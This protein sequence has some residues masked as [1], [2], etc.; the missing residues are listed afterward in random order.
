MWWFV[1]RIL[2]VMKLRQE[3][4]KLEAIWATWKKKKT[5][6]KNNK[7]Q[8]YSSRTWGF[9]FNHLLHTRTHAHARMLHPCTQICSKVSEKML[10]TEHICDDKSKYECWALSVWLSKYGHFTQY[11][12]LVLKCNQK[13]YKRKSI[14]LFRLMKTILYFY[15]STVMKTF[16]YIWGKNVAYIVT[17]G[18]SD[19]TSQQK[20]LSIPLDFWWQ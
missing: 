7:T 1:T 16:L 8:W 17:W 13:V 6:F 18:Y 12:V 19:G 5:L 2:V 4:H 10:T 11:I 15:Y 3:D 14:T 20:W 9:R